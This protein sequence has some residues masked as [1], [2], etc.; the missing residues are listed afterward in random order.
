MKAHPNR[1]IPMNTSSRHG[2]RETRRT[3]TAPNGNRQQAVFR[4][5]NHGFGVP[6]YAVGLDGK[7]LAR[8]DDTLFDRLRGF[9]Q[10]QL[11]HYFS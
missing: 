1:C 9:S 10:A 11:A 4:Q 2:V 6:S 7:T 3:F 8:V 5:I